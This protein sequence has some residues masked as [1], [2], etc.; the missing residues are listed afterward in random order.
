MKKLQKRCLVIDPETGEEKVEFRGVQVLVL[1][2]LSLTGFVIIV[3][4][5]VIEIIV[6]V[7]IVNVTIVI[8]I[9]IFIVSVIIVGIVIAQVAAQGLG[10][11]LEHSEKYGQ[12][13]EIVN[14]QLKSE[15]LNTYFLELDPLDRQKKWTNGSFLSTHPPTNFFL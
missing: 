12:I 4:I 15:Y 14:L 13:V 9:T 2:L 5:I 6:I 11:S 10:L 7:I 1:F 3:G 8:A